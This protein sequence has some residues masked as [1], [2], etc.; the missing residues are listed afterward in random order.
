MISFYIFDSSSIFPNRI[1]S[2]FRPKFENGYVYTIY[3]FKSH[4]NERKVVSGDSFLYLNNK[5]NKWYLP[6]STLRH[7]GGGERYNTYSK[8]TKNLILGLLQLIF[9]LIYIFVTSLYVKILVYQSKRKSKNRIDIE[10]EVKDYLKNKYHFENY[11]DNVQFIEYEDGSIVR[12][13]TENNLLRRVLTYDNDN[14]I[15]EIEFEYD[16][17]DTLVTKSVKNYKKGTKYISKISQ[18]DG[19]IMKE[20]LITEDKNENIHY[21]IHVSYNNIRNINDNKNFYSITCKR[22]GDYY[23]IITKSIKRV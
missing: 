19:L 20:D 21:E 7:L 18:H 17:K 23:F 9:N 12:D 3:E 14:L 8:D 22:N 5:F 4:P 13:F 10:N 16:K 2:V 15:E 11:G 1:K 6:F